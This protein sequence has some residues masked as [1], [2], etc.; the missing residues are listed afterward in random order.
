MYMHV[1][2]YVTAC[3]GYMCM[4]MYRRNWNCTCV[5]VQYMK[6]TL[7]YH[8]HV[9]YMYHMYTCTCTCMC[10][11]MCVY[12]RELRFACGKNMY[13]DLLAHLA[14]FSLHFSLPPSLSLSTSS[15][16]CRC[17]PNGPI[18]ISLTED[19]SGETDTQ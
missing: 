14:N 7:A 18:R 11:K 9:W 12:V 6:H 17:L 19:S 16:V 15:G 13:E 3:T 1:R 8:V 4:C 2:I 5:H 10:L